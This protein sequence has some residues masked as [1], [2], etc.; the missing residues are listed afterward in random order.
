MSGTKFGTVAIVGRP[1]SGKSSLVNRLCGGKV[2]IVSAVPQTTRNRVR[3]IVT[4][5]RGQLVLIDTPG[6]H[7]SERKLNRHLKGLVTSSLGEVDVV[8]YVVD[9]SRRPGEEEQ[10]I[11]DLVSTFAGQKA[12]VLNKSDVVAG[13]RAEIEAF[14]AARGLHGVPISALTGDGVEPL[15]ERLLDMAPEGEPHYPEDYYTDQEVEFRISEI[16]RE[17]AIEQVREEVPHALYVEMADTERQGEGL[18]VRAF[19]CVERES[20]KGI[21]IGKAASCIREIRL[22]A[23]RELAEIFPYPVRLDL[24]VKV[25]PNWRH[26]DDL[27]R[28]LIQ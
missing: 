15:H 10:K 1:S 3:G 5:A 26:R 20:Q 13:H 18:W 6:L 25:R 24:Q 16:I 11:A 28:R 22:R 23:E 8:L 19:V 21:L 9:L 2:S 17:K 12:V 14:L 4:T 27:L 7:D